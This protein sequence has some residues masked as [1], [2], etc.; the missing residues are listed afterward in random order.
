MTQIY[1]VSHDWHTCPV[2]MTYLRSIWQT[3]RPDCF[4]QYTNVFV[5]DVSGYVTVKVKWPIHLQF[6]ICH[7]IK[8]LVNRNY[9][10]HNTH[11]T[12][13][14][15]KK[16]KNKSLFLFIHV[17]WHFFRYKPWK[18]WLLKKNNINI[19]FFTSLI[20]SYC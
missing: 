20:L 19:I 12:K 3:E 13:R 16:V 1:L 4:L 9:F 18:Q 8:S 6:E 14:G 11:L 7:R 2:L 5:Q 15:R 10:E 17:R